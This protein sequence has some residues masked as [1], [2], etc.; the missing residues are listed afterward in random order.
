MVKRDDDLAS[1]C[2]V[3]GDMAGKG[4]HIGDALNLVFPGGRAAYAA[5]Q[6]N[7]CAGGQAAEWPECQHAAIQQIKAAPVDPR[8]SVGQKRG[9]VRQI[10][11]GV[12]GFI[13]QGHG[14]SQNQFIARR[15]ILGI[16]GLGKRHGG[17]SSFK[18]KR[19]R[20]AGRASKR[21]M[22]GG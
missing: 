16:T 13:Q 6:R 11:D 21:L 5:P 14:L 9:H 7:L 1:G 15:L 22:A 2:A 8:Q 4:V 19:K 17:C 20:G 12:E 18:A 10:G 3:A